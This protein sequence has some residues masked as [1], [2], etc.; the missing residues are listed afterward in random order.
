MVVDISALLRYTQVQRPAQNQADGCVS[1]NRSTHSAVDAVE[2][3][4]FRMVHVASCCLF[5]EPGWLAAGWMNS[6]VSLGITCFRLA[7]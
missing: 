7:G 6:G 3:V 4:S 5:V 1:E 2:D